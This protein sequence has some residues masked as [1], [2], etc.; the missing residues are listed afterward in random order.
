MTAGAKSFAKFSFG[1]D[2][3]RKNGELGDAD[4]KPPSIYHVTKTGATLLLEPPNAEVGDRFHFRFKFATGE[5]TSE[6][7]MEWEM[8][9]IEMA[10]DQKLLAKGDFVSGDLAPL[11]VTLDELEERKRELKEFYHRAR[12]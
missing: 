7:L 1:V 3:V 12:G 6:C 9:E 10:F 5:K 8:T 11:A 2:V 4:M